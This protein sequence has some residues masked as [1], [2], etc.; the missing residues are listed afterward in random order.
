MF[1]KGS[2]AVLILLFLIVRGQEGLGSPCWLGKMD[3]GDDLITILSSPVD[4]LLQV[5]K[6]AGTALLAMDTCAEKADACVAAN[7]C[8]ACFVSA[9][10]SSPGRTQS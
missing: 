2:G 10:I 1:D 4:L 3:F 7:A 5:F 6:G 8:P 9:H